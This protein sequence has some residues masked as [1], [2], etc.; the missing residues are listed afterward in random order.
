MIRRPPGSTRTDT[1]FPYTTLFRSVEHI[2]PDS[3]RPHCGRA[4]ANLEPG[5]HPH[6]EADAVDILACRAR[7]ACGIAALA[8]PYAPDIGCEFLDAL[9]A[10]PESQL[11]FGMPRSAASFG[12]ILSREID[13]C[14]SP[15][16]QPLGDPLVLLPIVIGTASGRARLGH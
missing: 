2:I 16:A 4:L 9:V 13:P 5:T 6:D 3:A 11:E 14:P 1:L 15:Q 8:S 10:K 7:E 12:D